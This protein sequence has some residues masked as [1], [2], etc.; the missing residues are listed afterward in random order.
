LIRDV[1]I[2]IHVII[3]V[4]LLQVDFVEAAF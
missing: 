1:E 2:E 4:Y 3:G